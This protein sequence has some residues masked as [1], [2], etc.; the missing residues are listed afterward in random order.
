[1]P[2][3]SCRRKEFFSTQCRIQPDLLAAGWT[4]SR[5]TAWVSLRAKTLRWHSGVSQRAQR[6]KE[7]GKCTLISNL[8]YKLDELYKLERKYQCSSQLPGGQHF[9]GGLVYLQCN[10]LNTDSLII[11]DELRCKHYW[12]HTKRHEKIIPICVI[13]WRAEH[14]LLSASLFL[15]SSLEFNTI[16]HRVKKPTGL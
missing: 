1:M 8:I 9:S 10:H 14:I 7:G 3:D 11:L 16:M 4:G 13:M 12:K 5:R 6:K 15:C 2:F